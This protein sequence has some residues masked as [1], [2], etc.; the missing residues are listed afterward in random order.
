MNKIVF[1]SCASK[2]LSHTAR[3]KYLYISPLFKKSLAFAR[4]LSPDKIFILSA[5]YGL[6]N[7]EQ[8]LKPYEQTLST[9]SVYEIKHWSE[10]VKS[11]MKEKINFET[12]EAVFLA[13]EKYRRHLIRLFKK[14]QVPLG[15][16]WHWKT[17]SVS[18][19]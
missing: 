1:I 11:Q 17:T 6:V 10:K 9:M 19:Q 2:K 15:G 4:S 5:K 13:G 12:S 7:L 18:Q 14:N 3:A 16:A 8:E